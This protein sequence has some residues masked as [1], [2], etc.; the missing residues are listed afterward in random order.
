M[1]RALMAV[2][3]GL[4]APTLA[5]AQNGT[6]GIPGG[7][8]GGTPGTGGPPSPDYILSV[9]DGFGFTGDIVSTTA[10]LDSTA[11]MD[12]VLGWSFSICHDPALVT[13]DDAVL[14][15]DALVGPPS[16]QNPMGGPGGFGSISLFADG[17]ATGVI[18]D[19]FGILTLPAGAGY[20]LLD[21]DYEV[22]GQ[23]GTADLE[24]CDTLGVPPTRSELIFQNGNSVEPTTQDGEIVIGINGPLYTFS[25][26]D[27]TQGFDSSSGDATFTVGVAVSE[28]AGSPNFPNATHG[29]S[30]A[31]GHDE[32]VLSATGASAGAG[33]A[34]LN[35]GA[36][37]EFFSVNTLPNGI[38]VGAVYSLASAAEVVLFDVAS[39]AVSIDY[40]T[41]AANLQGTTT[42]TTTELDWKSSLGTPA[43]ENLV[44]I[45]FAGAT[46][47]VLRNDGNVTLVPGGP[48]FVRGD[49][50]GDG[51]YN[52]GDPLAVL[53]NLFGGA[54]PLACDDACDGNDDGTVNLTDA[55][56]MLENLFAGGANPPAPVGACGADPTADSMSCTGYGCP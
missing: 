27:V 16:N 31:L 11:G 18:R 35:A 2:A 24:Y 43:I 41:N 7:G 21:I 23:A 20:E 39:E 12:E 26:P 48:F 22:L 5:V 17:V 9:D 50:S 4:L 10:K 45:D 51:N 30:M 36:G 29:F 32:D 14:G 49:C 6:I 19:I 56:Y 3:L 40:A 13:I 44:A 53:G 38:T 33:L 46:V 42:P 34:A 37:P 25:L 52:L 54:G 47:P 28:D 1:K 55:V 15:A 8:T